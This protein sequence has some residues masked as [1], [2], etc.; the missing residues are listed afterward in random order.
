MT[1]TLLALALAQ[2]TEATDSAA[3]TQAADTA[4][5]T[6][7]VEEPVEEPDPWA[8]LP[9]IPGQVR[10]DNSIWELELLYHNEQ[11]GEGLSRTDQMITADPK[12]ADLYWHAARFK[13]EIAEGFQRTDKSIDKEQW[14]TEMLAYAE[15][16]LKIDP[17]NAH[18]LFAKGIALG[19]LGTTRGV[20]ASLFTAQPIEQAW[21]D[22]ANSSYRYRSIAGEEQLPCD[23]DLTLGI[24]YRLVP[25]SWLVDMIAGTSGD[26]DKSLAHHQKA[27]SCKPRDI[28]IMK[29]MGA[30]QLCIGEKEGDAQSTARGRAT[31]QSALTIAPQTPNERID[32]GHMRMLLNDPGLACEYSRDG[33]Q[34]LDE[35]QLEK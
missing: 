15:T 33:Q 29:E 20:L 13:F 26:L 4:A 19:R 5:D 31:L 11:F 32:V 3:D 10:P 21:T 18:L 34:N 7:S 1:L 6:A 35:S 17:D 23:C 30:T 22:C 12:N 28:G 8:N 9:D 27:D 14:Y 16:G 25:D 24:F 2:D